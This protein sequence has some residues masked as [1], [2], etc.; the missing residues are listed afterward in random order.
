MID[1]QFEDFINQEVLPHTL[2]D[3]NKFW[4]DM[5][6]LVADFTPRNRALLVK[7]DYIQKQI[8]QWHLNNRYAPD[9]LST[10]KEFLKEIAYLVPEGDA[11]KIETTNVDAEISTI[12]GPQLVVPLKNSRFALNAANARWGSLYDALYGTDVIPQKGSLKAGP[13]YNP[14]R[15]QDVIAYGRRFLDQTVPLA[16]GSHNDVAEYS[17]HQQKLVV[18][19][20]DGL[21]TSLKTPKQL[22]A[23]GGESKSPSTLLLKNNELHLEIII[24]R[25]GVIGKNDAAGIN[26]I[27]LEAAVTTIMDCEDSVA[28]VDAEDKLEVY[29]NWL[30]LMRGTL[31]AEFSKNGKQVTRRLNQDRIYTAI[32]GSDYIVRSKSLLFNRNVG[33]LM[34]S[35]MMLDDNGSPI[36]EHIIDGV[37]T[38]LIGMID[39]NDETGTGYNNSKTKSIYIVKPKMHGPEEVAFVCEM[40]SAIE[41]MLGLAPFTIKLGIMDEER[42]TSVNLMECIRQAAKR[43]VFINTGF[44]DRTGDEIHTSMAAGPF[45]SKEK[46]KQQPW[47]K[48]YENRNVDIGLSCGLSGTA[49]IGKGMWPM[50]DEMEKMMTTKIQHPLAGANTAWVPS[51]TAAVL[52]AMH[53]HQ[54]NVLAVQSKLATRPISPLDDVLTIPLLHDPNS[55][56]KT[57]IH[58]E[59]R[60]NIQGVLG[61]VV[62]WVEAG[63]GCSK[64]PDINNIGLMEDRATLRISAKHIAN[65]LHHK[66]CT[67]QEVNDLMLE[68][69]KVVDEQNLR[70]ENYTPMSLDVEKSAG[71][72]AAKALIF[73]SQILPN[74]YTEP[75]LHK[76]RKTVKADLSPD[77]MA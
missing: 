75:V 67:E 77:L 24:D 74:G 73:N 59:L 5:D 4:Q 27:G 54:I 1:S 44:L 48:A 12:A 55:L 42:R 52:H 57:E 25:D 8:S 49:Q 13:N 76:Y 22:V 11:F 15:G 43:L 69:A 53:Y 40:F 29:R 39:L 61:Y 10:Y 7:R 37:V 19:L 31:S 2:L 23:F 17:I 66:L 62:R 34:T 65:W 35:E 45:L 68:M 41:Q 3:S 18:I 33:L 38:A 72:Q 50:P 36:P 63:I 64:V 9:D 14:L 58:E 32:D 26:D 16:E 51:P 6:S 60:N 56:S 71:F 46:I 21:Q 70:S 30:G 20:K 28:A 47:I